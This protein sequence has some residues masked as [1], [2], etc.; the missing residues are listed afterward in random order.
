MGCAEIL[1]K[2]L[3]TVCGKQRDVPVER[4]AV[5][6]KGTVVLMKKNVLNFK[7]AGSAFLDRMHELFGKRVTIQLVSAEH[8]DPGNYIVFSFYYEEMHRELVSF[9]YRVAR[10]Q[11][12][13]KT[14]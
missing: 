10:M 5:K 6:I 1:E 4:D 11:S 13:K 9:F 12:E 3:E 8:A 7:D 2:L 14:L